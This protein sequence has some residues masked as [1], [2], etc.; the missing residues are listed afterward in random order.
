LSGKLG[1]LLRLTM[2]LNAGRRTRLRAPRQQARSPWGMGEMRL[3]DAT[4]GVLAPR[5]SNSC[6]ASPRCG[7][8]C[9]SQEDA[10]VRLLGGAGP[11]HC[12]TGEP[13]ATSSPFTSPTTRHARPGCPHCAPAP[14]DRSESRRTTSAEVLAPRAS[15][16]CAKPTTSSCWSNIAVLRDLQR[17]LEASGDAQSVRPGRRSHQLR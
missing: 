17:I 12:Q 11:G 9:A 15:K 14:A 16:R 7:Q 2:R 5:I 10:A 1:Q 3:L 8:S 6:T 13:E 4:A